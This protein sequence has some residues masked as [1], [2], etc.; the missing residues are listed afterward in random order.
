MFRKKMTVKPCMLVKSSGRR[1]SLFTPVSKNVNTV[2]SPFAFCESIKLTLL[3]IYHTRDFDVL[4]CSPKIVSMIRKYHNPK[5]QT[6]QWHREEEPHNN[7][8]TSG[9]QTKQSN[10]LPLPYRDDCKFKQF[11]NQND[12]F[13]FSIIIKIILES[14]KI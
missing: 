13:I 4:H 1:S 3:N 7:H 12:K 8:V 14:I 10:Q 6:N 2:C 11:K 9:R 5:M